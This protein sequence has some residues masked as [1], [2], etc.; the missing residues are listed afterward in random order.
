MRFRSL[1]TLAAVL[2]LLFLVFHGTLQAQTITTGQLSGT[3]TDP[4]GAVVANASVQVKNLEDGSVTTGKTNAQ[5]AYQF[6]YLKPGDYSV[7]VNAAG[8]QAE[9]RKV[10]V[11]LGASPAAN[12]QLSVGSSTTTVEV[13]GTSALV[14]TENANVNAN[15]NAKALEMLPN[16]GN[17]LSVVALTT[18]GA[19]MNTAG[20]AMF[21]GGNFEVNGLPATSN[22]FTL[23]GSNDND[24]YFNVNN[25]GATNLTLGLN[26]V[27][28]STVVSNGYSGS[29]GGLA[30]ANVNYVTKSGTN[31]FHGNAVYWWNGD[32]L[33][34][35]NYFRVQS[36][37]LAGSDV[38]PRP[39]VN[40]NQYAGSFG[41]PI[42]K[43]KA[44]FFFDIEGLQLAIPSPQTLFVPTPAFQSAVLGNLNA[45]GLSASVPFYQTMFG[46][47]NRV[48][49]AGAKQVSGGGCSDVTTLNGIAF[50][51]ANPC[52]VQVQA[53]LQAHTHD[54]LYVGKVDFNLTN[55]DKLFV[56]VE[57][58]HGLQATYTDGI[59]P[60]FNATSDQPQWQS[61][62][63]E[64]HNFG[65][66]KVNDFKASLLWY[67]AFFRMEDPA[68]AA[69]ALP[70]N[71][72]SATVSL[73]DGSLSAL[74]NFGFLLPQGRNITQYQFVDDF[75]WLHGRHNFRVGV[76]FHRDLITDGN[77]VITTPYVIPFSLEN[78]ATGGTGGAGN[79]VVQAF[80]SR[81]EQRIGLYQLGFY[82]SDDVRV[83]NDLK[84]TL[85]LRFDHLSNPTCDL[86]C[87]QRFTPGAYGDSTEPVNSAITS[88]L[89]QAFPSVTSIVAQP[90]I[91]F[92]W[93]P[94]GSQKTVL[95]GGIGIFGDALPTGAIDDFLQNAPL[96][97]QFNT[98]SGFIAPQQTGNIGGITNNL[99]ALSQA[100]NT[101]F[102]ANYNSGGVGCAVAGANPAT[103]VPA[104][105]FYN[106]TTVK[107][108]VYYKWS[109]EVQREVGWKTTVNVLYVGNHGSHEEFSN[110][111]LNAFCCIP[112]QLISNGGAVT[113]PTWAN[114]PTT[115][116]D[117]RFGTVSQANNIANSNYN[118]LTV[119]A[120]HAFA[121]GFQFLAAYTWSHALDEISNNSLSP[122]GLNTT[123]QYID[124]VY[125]QDPFNPGRNYGNADYDIRHNFTMNYVW[126]DAFRHITSAGPNALVKGWTFSGTIFAHT[127]L[128]FTIYSSDVTNAL[129]STN[130]GPGNGLTYAFSNQ[131]G[132]PASCGPSAATVSPTGAGNPCALPANWTN[133]IANYGNQM[134][135]QNRGPAYFNTDFAVEKAFGIPKWEG[136]QFSVGARFFN[137]FNHPNFYFPIMNANSPSFGTI[138]ETATN[139]TGIYGSGLGADNSVRAIQLQAKFQF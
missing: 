67:S 9:V 99:Y 66:D 21:G 56:R 29:Y 90:K 39:F 7:T 19:V 68:A 103:C 5:G 2:C 34:A 60:A 53:A 11:A 104:F 109:L 63:G 106:A 85:S 37:A 93:S 82:G 14:E 16:P 50:G 26:D 139:P 105:N 27:S 132:G 122:F 92:A 79:V 46:L 62:V 64:T 57:N 74:N 97:P 51:A 10:S 124:V 31:S 22:L 49:Q 115:I 20:G 24:P 127:G 78:F 138:I 83:T 54:R 65:A 112:S 40:A 91:G 70:V 117:A 126:S 131:I 4:S 8:F 45:T 113:G 111:A 137:L 100:S 80:P 36:N 75:S 6:S 128:P 23:D 98:F 48:S 71:G 94:F 73:G 69:A 77:F 87:F 3:V 136:A 43:D 59:D 30:G 55:S 17:D 96:D 95:R 130:Y 18:P 15:F 123:G 101:A 52:A 114:L 58:E 125:P 135:N 88:G 116:P 89:H 102:K 121:G 107:V 110:Q 35:N 84:L 42:K 33:D 28:E 12:F 25:S 133:P 72:G 41:G 47:Y 119:S 108:P 81:S 118:G 44:F 134:R 86:N 13:T 32:V 61:Q 1:A 76:N 38:N 120:N 129:E